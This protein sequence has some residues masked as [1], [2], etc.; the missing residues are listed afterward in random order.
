MQI[1]RRGGASLIAAGLLGCTGSPPSDDDLSCPTIERPQDIEGVVQAIGALP[2]PLELPCFLSALP[3]PLSI[4]ATDDIFSAQPAVGASSPRI[5]ILTPGLSMSVVPEGI[6]RPLLE[7]GQPTEPGQSLKAELHFP[8]TEP[9]SSD[10]PF[11]RI[12]YPDQ[13][14]TS[15]GVC[16]GLEEDLGEGRFASRALRP[17]PATLVGV[18]RLI[19]EASGCDQEH[20]PDRCAML[21][22]LFLSGL[23]EQ[24]AFPE[25]YDTIY[26]PR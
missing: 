23:V 24:G 18:E 20:Q 10:D 21:G 5:F 26:D 25:H 22:A 13:Q 14:G 8:I 19:A 7:L 11:T 6:G 3:R 2:L 17:D 4:V 1:S 15:C 9:V 12:Q 16:H